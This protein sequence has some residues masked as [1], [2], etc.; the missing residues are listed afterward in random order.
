MVHIFRVQEFGRAVLTLGVVTLSACS[1]HDINLLPKPDVEISESYTIEDTPTKEGARQLWWKHFER[2][3][4]DALVERSLGNNHSLRASMAAIRQAQEVRRSA[5]T[6]RLPQIDVEGDYN[7][8]WRGSDAQRASGDVGAALSWELDIFGRVGYAV[9][10]QDYTIKAREADLEALKL[11]LSAEVANAY[12]GAAAAHRRLKLL[13]EQVRLD[14][15]LQELLQLRLDNGV[16]T[17]VDLLQQMAR[18]ADS[19]T[20]IPN[21]EFDLA[22]FENRLDVLLGVMPDGQMRVDT[23]EDLAFVSDMPSVSIPADLLAQRPDLKAKRAE[24]IAADASIGAAM[25]DYFPQVNIDGS[26]LFTDALSYT[27]PVE[28]IMGSFVQPLL[29][30]GRRKAEVARNKALYEEGLAEYTQLFLEAVE[31]VENALVQEQKQREFLARLEKQRDILKK[32]VRLSE[33]RYKQGIDDYLPVINSLQELR[34]VE[35]DLISER[36]ELVQV[37][38]S[39]HRAIGGPVAEGII[40]E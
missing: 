18:V 14:R 22:V 29:D 12:F 31:D 21:T 33:D 23:D 30:W 24:L 20:L 5:H 26:Y 10:A 36:L 16:G 2:P 3:Q 9:Q 11:S 38:I 39:L 19:E 15:E 37:R 35:R 28:M 13:Q 6:E 4:L 8:S 34:Q 27:G 17:N 40:E 32:A 7:K 25:A 1:L